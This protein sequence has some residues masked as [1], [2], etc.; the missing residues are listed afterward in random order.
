MIAMGIDGF[1]TCLFGGWCGRGKEG[2]QRGVT[3]AEGI[4]IV[5][6]GF[7]GFR[8]RSVVNPIHGKRRAQAAC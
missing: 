4:E 7:S 6:F 8:D 3:A 1:C 5:L 2:E